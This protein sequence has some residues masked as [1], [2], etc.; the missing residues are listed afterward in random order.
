[1]KVR[2]RSG[3]LVY[4]P[5]ED[6]RP[7]DL[8][9]S[10]RRIALSVDSSANLVVVATPSGFANALAEE[11]DRSGHPRVLGTIAGDN[12]ILIIAREGVPGRELRDELRAYL[13]EG[14]A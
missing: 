7:R 12:T 14:A 6:A 11:I 4:A 10:F 13:T 5:P 3:R 2:R 1:V 9:P 8:A